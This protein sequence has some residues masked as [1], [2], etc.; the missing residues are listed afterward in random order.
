MRADKKIPAEALQHVEIQDMVAEGKCLVRVGNLVIFVSQVAPGDVVDLRVTKSKKSFLEA[1]PTKFHKYSELRVTPFCQHFGTC[2]GCKWQHLGYDTQ[3]RYKQQQVED[4]LQRIGKVQLPEIQ[5][6]LPSPQRTYYRNKLEYT[7][8][9]N[10]WLTEDQIKDDTQQ[11][12]RRVLG[13][14]TPAR[15]DKIIDIQH[16]HL[17]PEPSNEIRLFI[18]DYARE[19][20]LRFGNIVK[21]TGNLRNLIVRTAQTTGE[22]MVILQCYLPHHSIEPLLD[23]VY[24]KFPQITSLNYVLNNKGNETFHDLEV[25]NYKGKPYIEEEME[26]LRFRIGPKSFYQTNSEGAYQLYK[27]ARD[28][29]ELKGNELVYDL[30]TGA[31]T[32]ASFVSKQAKRV[33]GVEYVEQAV[34]DAHVNAE[35]NGITN[36]AFVAGDMKDILTPAFT[37]QHGQPDLIITDPPRAGM[38]PDVVQRLLEMRCPRIV[39]ISCNPATQARDLE[40]L[41]AAY[42]V[43][44]VQPVD[45]FPHTHHVENVVLLELK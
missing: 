6:I 27:V 16:C 41:D 45:M 42:A 29:A 22:I 24:A 13:F 17:Q 1:V 25:V 8:S 32:I 40:L 9:F 18:R 38:H 11:Y 21:Q 35:I 30:Y 44:R 28:F 20:M 26:G 36:M 4:T 5:Q 43:T 12:D 39:Y 34:A 2:G 15:F 33:I 19:H 37:E 3:L 10:G 31:G 14:H 7:F 23:A